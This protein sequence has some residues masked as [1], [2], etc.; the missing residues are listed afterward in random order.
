LYNKNWN[1]YYYSTKTKANVFLSFYKYLKIHWI[2][3]EI[4]F[5]FSAWYT[6]NRW[7]IY[8]IW[9]KYSN[10][11]KFNYKISDLVANDD[12]KVF[13]KV[14]N[15]SPSNLYLTAILKEYPKDILKVKDFSNKL[16]VS[17]T[18]YKV[19]N[20]SNLDKCNNYWFYS[21]EEE[22]LDC[23]NSIKKVETD[24]FEKWALYLVEDKIYSDIDGDKLTVEDYLPWTFQVVNS[25]FKT[26][27]ALIRQ[28]SSQWDY[29]AHQEI[30]PW[31]A[32]FNYESIRS[33]TRT[34]H[35]FVRPEFSWTYT[36]PPLTA[37]FMYKPEFR[38]NTWY[39]I[40][41]VK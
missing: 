21:E 38:A 17:R 28:N 1:S 9:W 19:V 30:Y 37:Y 5:W 3:R 14:W 31:V 26:N 24:T 7:D 29:R 40:I 4:R 25:K 12:K 22:N 13:V 6:F 32:M 34:I 11:K 2:N 35:Y 33:W 20:I 39:K 8:F 10:I 36:L 23:E 18:I 16:K 15:L 41:K 27:S